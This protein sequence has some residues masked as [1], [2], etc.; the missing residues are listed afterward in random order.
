MCVYRDMCDVDDWMVIDWFFYSFKVVDEDGCFLLS[1]VCVVFFLLC[2]VCGE[3]CGWGE[4][5]VNFDVC[6]WWF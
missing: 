6:V 2:V 4:D 5:D 3:V 1:M